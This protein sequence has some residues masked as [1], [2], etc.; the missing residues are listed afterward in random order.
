MLDEYLLIVFPISTLGPRL[1]S[2]KNHRS[3]PLFSRKRSDSFYDPES[4][5]AIKQWILIQTFDDI[6][7]GSSLNIHIDFACVH[8]FVSNNKMKFSNDL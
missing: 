4:F 8:E 3:R 5:Y 2:Y 7:K 6:L 1:W